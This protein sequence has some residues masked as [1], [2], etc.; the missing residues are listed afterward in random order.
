MAVSN[1]KDALDLPRVARRRAIPWNELDTRA[2]APRKRA[3]VGASWLHRMRQ[4]HL[5]VGAFAALT[6]ELAEVGC[7]SV[8]LSLVA[9]ASS[10]EVRHADIC[11]RL[12]V[13]LLGAPA[14]PDRVRGT[15]RLPSA[16][17]VSQRV[18]ALLHVVE[19]CCINET[20]TGV[21]LTEM[22]HRAQTDVARAAIASLLEDEIDH[23]R[24]GWA[25]LATASREG[26]GCK[27]VGEALPELL[28]RAVDDVI[29]GGRRSSEHDDPE[30]EAHGFIGGRASAELYARALDEVVLPG[31][32]ALDVPIAAARELARARGWQ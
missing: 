22:L 30:M 26:W 5:A 29:R 3:R 14:V 4:E 21:F 15:P 25:Y 17:G 27:E 6:A 31:F 23:G 19:M 28:V 12:A 13:G 9:R 18:Q 32:D 11:R 8:V 10:D 20:L 1:P 7:P 2:L 16:A 24:V